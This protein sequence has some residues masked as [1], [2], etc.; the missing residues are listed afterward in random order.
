MNIKPLLL[1]IS[2]F[3]LSLISTANMVG[4][5]A[6]QN[7]TETLSSDVRYSVLSQRLLTEEEHN[8]QKDA[9]ATIAV[10]IRLSNERDQGIYYLGSTV[11]PLMPVGHLLRRKAG[12]L[13]W[14]NPSDPKED[15]LEFSGE[16]YVWV[17]LPSRAAIEIEHAIIG[18][19]TEEQ[20]FSIY[21]K[22]N[23]KAKPIQ[24]ISDVFR[25]LAR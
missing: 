18:N 24:A 15:A 7:K 2:C 8:Q 5:T 23:S 16:G 14:S 10:R 11:S 25:P 20:A 17:W 3:S 13:K 9:F 19:P 12:E 4:Q 22:F 1:A 21:V 6:A